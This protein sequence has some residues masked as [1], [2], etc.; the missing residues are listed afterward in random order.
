M[1]WIQSEYYSLDTSSQMVLV[2][3]WNKYQVAGRWHGARHKWE[4]TVSVPGH[5]C[6]GGTRVQVHVTVPWSLCTTAHL[7]VHVIPLNH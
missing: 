6:V 2:D 4:H 1:Q 7:H 3:S 5:Q